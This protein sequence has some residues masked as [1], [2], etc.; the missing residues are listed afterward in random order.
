MGSGAVKQGVDDDLRRVDTEGAGGGKPAAPAAR[1]RGVGAQPVLLDD[2]RVFRLQDLDRGVA[3]VAIVRAEYAVA[4]V[5]D[6]AAPTASFDVIV[7]VVVAI[8]GVEAAEQ[9][10]ARGGALGGGDPLRHRPGQR[11]DDDVL[12]M[13][14]CLGVAADRR[15]GVLDVHRDSRAASPAESAGR[16]R[17]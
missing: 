13:R 12:D 4:V 17:S 9:E 15:P 10:V 5:V 2:E 11:P 1:S 6:R 14:V 3:A 7:R 16:R 8:F